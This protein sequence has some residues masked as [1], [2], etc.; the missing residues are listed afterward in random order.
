MEGSIFKKDKVKITFIRKALPREDFES[1]LHSPNPVSLEKFLIDFK[2][3]EL[4]VV[5]REKVIT[6][7]AYMTVRFHTEEAPQE[8]NVQTYTPAPSRKKE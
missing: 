8:E 3:K 4:D 2:Y 7:S 6:Q 1:Y 5:G